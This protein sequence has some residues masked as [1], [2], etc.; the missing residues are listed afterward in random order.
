M[1]ADL[2]YYWPSYLDDNRRFWQ[3]EWEWHGTCSGLSVREYFERSLTLFR[4]AYRPM[5][6]AI[7]RGGNIKFTSFPFCFGT[8]TDFLI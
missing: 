4:Q 3:H 7:A 6:N 1:R 5:F 2:D 8:T